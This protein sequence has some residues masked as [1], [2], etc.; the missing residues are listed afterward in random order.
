[1]RSGSIKLP[2]S[3]LESA[4]AHIFFYVTYMDP[5]RNEKLYNC[6]CVRYIAVEKSIAGHKQFDLNC[7]R[8]SDEDVSIEFHG[9]F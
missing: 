5:Q 9:W 4:A 7:Q 6:I 2:G 3:W 8:W 1:M